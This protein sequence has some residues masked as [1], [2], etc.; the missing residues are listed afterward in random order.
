M[1]Q[2]DNGE[3]VATSRLSML[4]AALTCLSHANYAGTHSVVNFRKGSAYVISN[5]PF[6]IMGLEPAN[7]TDPPDVIAYA[8]IVDVG[9]IY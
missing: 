8:V 2:N 9:P 7:I 6:R 5:F 1:R 3:N 4:F